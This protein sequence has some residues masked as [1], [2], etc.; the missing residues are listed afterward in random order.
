[1]TITE[2]P[3]FADF[4]IYNADEHNATGIPASVTTLADAVRAADGVIFVTPEYNFSTPGGLKNAIDWV[5][6]FKDQ[7]FK[8]KPVAIQSASPGPVG[9]ARVQYHLRQ[10]LVFLDAL[11]FTRPEIFVGNCASKFDEKGA[12]TDE[13]TRGFIKSQLEAFAKFIARH[14]QKA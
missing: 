3:P 6:R 13:T 1:M 7:P 4:P 2:A 12:L 8:D 14:G 5:S 9:G 10:T 11:T